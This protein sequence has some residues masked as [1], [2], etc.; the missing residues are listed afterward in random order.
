MATIDLTT[1][2]P[3]KTF[4]S[5]NFEFSE[6]SNN[7]TTTYD[8]GTVFKRRFTTSAPLEVSASLLLNLTEFTQFRNFYSMTTSE[9]TLPFY[10]KNPMQ[11]NSSL[12]T[13]MYFLEPPRYNPLEGNYWNAS[14]RLRVFENDTI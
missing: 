14:L 3:K 12:K 2:L 6:A 10:F 8:D 9:G 4:L 7:I 13:K 1:L 11:T 5:D